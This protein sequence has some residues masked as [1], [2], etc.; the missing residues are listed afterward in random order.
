MW[1]VYTKKFSWWKIDIYDKPYTNNKNSKLKFRFSIV[2]QLIYEAKHSRGKIL[3]NL[4]QTKKSI[5]IK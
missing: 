4:D 3:K 2:I 5:L 1:I